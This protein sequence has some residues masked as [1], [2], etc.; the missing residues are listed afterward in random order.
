[1]SD[2]G[3]SAT[4][5]ITSNAALTGTADPNAA[6]NLTI[7]GTAAA[8]SA[9]A[10][11]SGVWSFTPTGLVDGQHTVVASETNAAGQTGS[12][13]LTFTLDTTSASG[14]TA[15][16]HRATARVGRAPA[17]GRPRAIRPH[18]RPRR[19]ALPVVTGALVSDTGASATDGITSN[20]ALTGT[21]DPNAAIN[22][23]IDG[24]AAATRATADA[25][26]VWSFTPTGLVDGQHTVVASETNA[27]GQTGSANLSFTLDTTSA[28]GS[29]GERQL[30]WDHGHR[31]GC[32]HGRLDLTAAR[33]ERPAGRDRGP[34]ERHRHLGDRRH[35]VERRPDRR[36]RQWRCRWPSPP[37]RGRARPARRQIHTHAAS[38]TSAGELDTSLAQVPG[39]SGHLA[40]LMGQYMAAGFHDQQTGAGA[41]DSDACPE[42]KP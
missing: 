1:M 39:H 4:D 18:R 28:S 32:D 41:I 11:A 16:R 27:A 6:V 25:S 14:S 26:G 24:T 2:T 23:T 7:D 19:A 42:G 34:G 40:G 15:Q 35:H 29:T 20:A 30:G 31:H 33:G 22:L 12:A 8:T 36:R 9:T 17:R 3:A 5:G 37:S 21:A 10:D 38:T 13:S